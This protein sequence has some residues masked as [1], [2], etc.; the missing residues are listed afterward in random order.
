MVQIMKRRYLFS[1]LPVL[2]IIG[3]AQKNTVPE[4]LQK[5]PLMQVQVDLSP[6]AR[7]ALIRGNESIIV[8]A[9]W[10]GWPL[11]GKENAADDVGQI[12]L[13]RPKI[14]LPASGGVARFAPTSLKSERLDWIKG[15]V[16]VNVNV[17]SARHHWADNI[18]ACDVIDDALSDVSG[19][20]AV[21]NCSLI[22]ERQPGRVVG[23]NTNH[24]KSTGLR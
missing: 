2:F 7:E 18:L 22:S 9:S 13:G 3:C 15:G 14:L 17:Y 20:T 4:T 21:L 12:D 10:Y 16:Q 5:K 24:G 11:P 19:Q 8:S 23:G 1:L 6:Q